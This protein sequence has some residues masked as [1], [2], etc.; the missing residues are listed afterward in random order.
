M[1]G[2]GAVSHKT[3]PTDES[4]HAQVRITVSNFFPGTEE[5][6]DCLLPEMAEYARADVQ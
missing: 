2:R 1:E 3:G 6:I 4:T 5:A